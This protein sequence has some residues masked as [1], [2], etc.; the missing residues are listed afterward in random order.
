V[1]TSARRQ[2]FLSGRPLVL[3]AV[4]ALAWGRAAN[5]EEVNVFAA[6]SLT[7]ALKEIAQRFEKETGHKV[8]FNLGGSNDLARQIEAGAPAD[9]F[10]SADKPQMDR[11]ENAGLV[12]AQ[13]RVD[14]LSNVLVVVVPAGSAAAI[15]RA[16]DL[17]RLDR[18]ALADPQAVPAGVYARTWLESL[19]LWSTLEGKVV[20]T[21]NVRAALAAVEAENAGAGIVYRTDAAISKRVKVA[22]EVPREQG[23]AILYPLAPLASSKKPAT[24]AIV[25]Y[26]ASDVTRDVYRRHGFVVLG[27]K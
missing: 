19:H 5:A 16:E 9:V 26:L 15:A 27:G 20:P 14:V 25:R 11:L 3:A 10:F 21:L 8:V 13:D 6:A 24:A 2:Y 12:R 7:D 18:L 17:Q 22:F 4:A 1:T 23:P